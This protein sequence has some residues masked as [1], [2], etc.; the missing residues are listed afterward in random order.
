M[1]YSFDIVFP[2]I[3]LIVL[4]LMGISR[5]SA[6]ENSAL[7]ETGGL[8][9]HELRFVV[10]DEKEG[11]GKT[12]ESALRKWV[13]ISEGVNFASIEDLQKAVDKDVQELVNLNVFLDVSAEIDRL[14]SDA[15]Q[16]I[17][18]YRITDGLTF[19]PIPL[20]LYNSNYGGVQLLYVQIWDNVFG[21]LMN[22]FH[23]FS[24]VVRGKDGGGLETGPFVFQPQLSRVKLGNLVM[25]FGLEQE[26]LESRRISRDGTEQSNYQLDR[27]QL[28]A[29]SQWR[30]G[31]DRY[32]YYTAKPGIEFRYNYDDIAGK[33]GFDQF[34]FQFNFKQD[35]AYKSTNVFFN[36]RKGFEVELSNTTQFQQYS[37]KN[38]TVN[39]D[40]LI[41][42]KVFFAFGKEG[43]ISYYPRLILYHIFNGLTEQL[44]EYMRGVTDVTMD[45]ASAVFLNQTLGF[46]IWKWKN[47]WDFQIH[48]YFD[49]GFT[50]GGTRR[51]ESINDIRSSTGADF[52]LFIEKVPNL[53][54][55][56]TWGI[57]LDSSI[58]L[59]D[60]TKT[61]FIVR[62]SYSY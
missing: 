10:Q 16:I 35:I 49:L 47:V 1:R 44:G 2:K 55:R 54:F 23:I 31:P 20:P 46:G 40:M 3:V 26:H 4:L 18:T 25:S 17:V 59:G 12:R 48:P 43:R 50:L 13:S 60:R 56:F 30:F 5:L 45:G 27:T 36:S 29:S 42:A 14:P 7:P 19:I 33:G 38:W 8:S 32:F 61:E 6:Q 41:I 15:S 11:G 52:L 51:L 24:L 28:Y 21:S 9:I 22:Y 34:P 58:P 37:S 57:D 62:Y 39:T 53:V